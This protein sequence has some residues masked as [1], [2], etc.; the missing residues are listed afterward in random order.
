MRSSVT[1][2]PVQT[3]LPKKKRKKRAGE[4]WGDE[5]RTPFRCTVFLLQLARLTDPFLALIS[6]IQNLTF[7][8]TD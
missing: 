2:T 5:R 1:K 4:R 8:T 3:P 7:L 6:S